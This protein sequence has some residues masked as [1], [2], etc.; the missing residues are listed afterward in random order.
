MMNDSPYNRPHKIEVF[1]DRKGEFRWRRKA[2]NSQVISTGAEGYVRKR[3][4]MHGLKIANADYKSVRID[5]LTS[6]EHEKG[7][8]PSS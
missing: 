6:Y 4:V 7:Q 8:S 2:G 5:D 3:D 1:Q